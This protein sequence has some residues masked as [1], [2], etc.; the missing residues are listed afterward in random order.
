MTLAL[1][2][3]QRSLRASPIFTF[4]V[5]ALGVLASVRA[6]GWPLTAWATAIMPAVL[7]LVSI[8]Y[9]EATSSLDLSWVLAAL[10]WGFVFLVSA[11]LTK[12]AD[13]R[14]AVGQ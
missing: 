3:L 11:Q 13:A 6:D 14:A 10:V 5:I 4:T 2:D 9:P 7:G 8:M 12:P 1:R